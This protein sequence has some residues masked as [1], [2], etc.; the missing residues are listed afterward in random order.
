MDVTRLKGQFRHQSSLRDD[1]QA[2]VGSANVLTTAAS[3]RRFVRGYRYGGG[4]AAA[5]ALPRS[6][7]EYWRVVQICVA[8]GAAV[9][10]QAANTGLT[11]GSVPFGAEYGRDVVVVSTMRIKRI[12]LLDNGRQVVAFPGT[13]LD[14][15]E[16]ALSPLGREPHSVIGS[17][18]LGASVVGGICN[19]SGGSLI[20]RGPAYTELALFGQMRDDGT[21]HLVNHLGIELGSSPEEILDRLERGDFTPDDITWE[22][23]ASDK[24]YQTH[25]RDVNADTPARFNAD[26]RKLYEASGSAGKVMVFA[27]RV[28]TF[29]AEKESMVY[30]I[31]TNDPDELTQIRRSVLSNFVELPIAAEYL[32][33]DAFDVAARYGKDTYLLVKKLGTARL[34]ALFAMKSK[35]DSFVERVPFL[36]TALSDL[37]LQF[38]SRV[39]PVHL[40]PR[41]L[42]Y[43]RR[44]EHHLMLKVAG[45]AIEETEI[46]LRQKFPSIAGNFFA[47]TPYEGKAAFLHRFAAAGAA[48][49]YN[50]IH[51]KSVGGI[52]A[53]DIALPRSTSEWVERLPAEIDD[54]LLKRFY[55]GHFFCH[56]FHQDYILK[57]GEDWMAV[58]HDMFAVLDARNARYPA[59][60]NFG[61]LY[62]APNAVSAHYRNLDPCNCF[63]PG[64]GKTSKL[65]RWRGEP[66][67]DGP[68]GAGKETS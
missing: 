27:V 44:Y 61:Q 25:V 30:Y 17:S 24:D 15:L 42:E 62:S 48:V 31:G 37:L 29:E 10:A 6:L 34:P 67:V 18:C 58:E 64:I 68:S 45:S 8:H 7:M 16:T 20:K 38:V 40:P 56:V 21:L 41:L 22:R 50:Q 9:I 54:R 47:C 55:Y 36:P 4:Q 59:E 60:H 52:V 51:K 66:L 5:V 49:R 3:M 46:L 57:Q 1:L 28:D 13:T 2:V 23:S 33:R 39:L 32:H 63:N 11:G 14:E 12:H 65:L 35:V 53:L 19:N 26:D 43:R